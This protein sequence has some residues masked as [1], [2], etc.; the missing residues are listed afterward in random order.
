VEAAN[1]HRV[2]L[3]NEL[4][5]EYQEFLQEPNRDREDSDDRPDPQTAPKRPR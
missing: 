2:I 4:K 5:S 1:I 3:E